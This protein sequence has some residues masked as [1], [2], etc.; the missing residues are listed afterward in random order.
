MTIAIANG[1]R[2]YMD[3]FKIAIDTLKTHTKLHYPKLVKTVEALENGAEQLKYLHEV[4][5][6]YEDTDNCVECGRLMLKDDMLTRD[7]GER[8]C[9]KHDYKIF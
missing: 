9:P 5:E 6:S 3:Y 7:D 8:V 2:G 4:V 1:N